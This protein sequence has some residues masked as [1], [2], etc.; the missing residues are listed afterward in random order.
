MRIFLQKS[1]RFVTRFRDRF[2]MQLQFIAIFA[3][4]H[5]PHLTNTNFHFSALTYWIAYVRSSNSIHFSFKLKFKMY[6]FLPSRTRITQVHSPIFRI[7]HFRAMCIVHAVVALESWFVFNEFLD[8][9]A[10]AAASC[11]RLMCHIAIF[12]LIDSTFRSRL[13]IEKS[14][15]SIM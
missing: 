12:L 11:N 14:V 10:A 3:C 5:A 6:N 9:A 4:K 2:Y 15:N 13:W 8:F 1:R 7:R